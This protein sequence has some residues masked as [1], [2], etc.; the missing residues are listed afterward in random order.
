M[1]IEAHLKSHVLYPKENSLPHPYFD[2]AAVSAGLH[3][4]FLHA[5]G[6]AHENN[7]FPVFVGF[8]G[9]LSVSTTVLQILIVCCSGFDGMSQSERGM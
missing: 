8:F 4:N 5:V 6:G 1:Q 7:I 2:E 9:F 3:W